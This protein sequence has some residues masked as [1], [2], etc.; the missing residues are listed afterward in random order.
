MSFGVG[1]GDIAKVMGLAKEVVTR[2]RDAPKHVN[3]IAS[4]CVGFAPRIPPMTTGG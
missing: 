1:F 3:D 2:Y 4:E